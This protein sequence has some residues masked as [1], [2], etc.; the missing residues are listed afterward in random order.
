MNVVPAKGIDTIA[1][2]DHIRGYFMWTVQNPAISIDTGMAPTS[3]KRGRLAEARRKALFE[4]RQK[5]LEGIYNRHDS[6][7]FVHD[8]R[9]NS[10]DLLCLRGKYRADSQR[11]YSTPRFITI[12]NG[13]R[14]RTD[15]IHD[16]TGRRSLNVGC[17]RISRAG[18]RE[19]R[20][21]DS[22]RQ[23]HYQ[24][25]GRRPCRTVVEIGWQS[26]RMDGDR[27]FGLVVE[28]L[29]VARPSHRN[30][31]DAALTIAQHSSWR[32]SASSRNW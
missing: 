2:V 19:K 14:A 9:Q 4:G 31:E 1:H 32:A 21:W 17:M 24:D 15:S 29:N 3:R 25:I 18:I 26:L 20:G 22:T 16:E 23:G 7:V 10:I 8:A 28:S 11:I 5:E 27:S 12:D 6:S 30:P 13:Q